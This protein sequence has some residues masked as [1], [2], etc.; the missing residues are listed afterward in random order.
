MLPY[1]SSIS[2]SSYHNTLH[3]STARVWSRLDLARKKAIVHGI[4]DED[5]PGVLTFLK[6]ACIK[7]AG[8]SHRG[9]IYSST[10]ENEV[11]AILPSLLEAL[12]VAS[13]KLRLEDKSGVA[14]V[15]DWEGNRMERRLG[16]EL[17]LH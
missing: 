7:I 8:K 5:N 10:I 14:Y 13:G 17:S 16:Y 6:D 3:I 12:K 9:D 4:S 1:S 15:Y 2:K 11:R